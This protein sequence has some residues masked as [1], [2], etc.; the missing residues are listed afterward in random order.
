VVYNL[1][2]QPEKKE[3]KYIM[4]HKDDHAGNFT[5][6]KLNPKKNAGVL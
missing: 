6:K 4:Y 2:V 5:Q 1:S 3:G